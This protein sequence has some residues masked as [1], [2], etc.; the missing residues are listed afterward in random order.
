MLHDKGPLEK[1][2]RSYAE[3]GLNTANFASFFGAVVTENNQEDA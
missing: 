3:Y 1:D 2:Y